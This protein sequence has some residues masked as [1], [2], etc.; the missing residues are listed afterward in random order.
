MYLKYNK[1][2]GDVKVSKK[3]LTITIIIAIVVAVMLLLM[4]VI[5]TEITKSTVRQLNQKVQGGE[6][7]I[8]ALEAAKETIETKEAVIVERDDLD[9]EPIKGRIDDDYIYVT[10]SLKNNGTR[11]VSFVKVKAIYYDANMTPLN[12]DWTYAVGVEGLS[13]GETTQFELMTK[14]TGDLEKY[15]LEV[16]DWQ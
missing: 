3:V 1:H 16:I 5:Q 15:K 8:A 10:G 12:T 7:Y 2:L 4:P 6:A 11:T 14:F 9:I 13:P